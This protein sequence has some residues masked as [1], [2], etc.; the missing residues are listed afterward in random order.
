MEEQEAFFKD[1]PEG[2]A[3]VP[4]LDAALLTWLPDFVQPVDEEMSQRAVELLSSVSEAEAA[5]GVE[6][7]PVLDWIGRAPIS[8]AKP[9]GPF[10]GDLMPRAVVTWDPTKDVEEGMIVLV[11]VDGESTLDRGWDLARVTRVETVVGGAKTFDG[12]W[13]MPKPP[14]PSEPGSSTS[15][16]GRGRGRGRDNGGSIGGSSGCNSGGS[17]GGS[18]SGTGNRGGGRSGRGGRG[19]RVAIR[20]PYNS[21]ERWA[22]GWEER[23]FEDIEVLRP[24]RRVGVWDFVR[25]EMEVVVWGHSIS[26]RGSV[27][28]RHQNWKLSKKAAQTLRAAVT[29]LEEESKNLKEATEI[30]QA[31]RAR[32]MSAAREVATVV[33]TRQAE[34]GV[35][36]EDDSEGEE[37]I[38]AVRAGDSES[39]SDL[40]ME[41]TS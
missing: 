13:L 40:E 16:R 28:R 4:A 31:A 34:V 23:A 33:R 20:I 15:R 19:T 36:A 14:P 2:N 25:L 3:G 29:W 6:F 27:A 10:E 8:Q 24:D 39:E 17:S 35:E 5:E 26:S 1:V 32:A 9:G 38:E 11:A 22:A 41:L 7:S 37:L 12:V 18:A 30:A 21:P